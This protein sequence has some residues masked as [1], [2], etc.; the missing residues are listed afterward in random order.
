[1]RYFLILLGLALFFPAYSQTVCIP[2]EAARYYLEV[3]EEAL[4]LR[5]KDSLS[6]ELILGLNEQILN[7]DRILETHQLENSSLRLINETLIDKN[8]LIIKENAKLR[9]KLRLRKTLEV[10]GAI[11]VVVLAVL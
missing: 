5:Q 3:H 7:Q 1:M 2:S 9:R 4:I 6:T 8:T 11:G 10:L